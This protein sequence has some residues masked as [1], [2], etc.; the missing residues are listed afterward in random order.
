[1]VCALG[2]TG[3]MAGPI[4]PAMTFSIDAQSYSSLLNDS[5]YANPMLAADILTPPTPGKPGPNAPYPA[6]QTPTRPGTF[7]ANYPVLGSPPGLDLFAPDPPY[8][9]QLDA[10]SFGRDPLVSPSGGSTATTLQYAFSVDE[11]A[12]GQSNT[13]V[14]TEGALGAREAA[15][16][17]FLS[18]PVSGM[19][20]GAAP[21]TNT[22]Y[23]DGNGAGSGGAPGIGLVE[24][25]PPTVGTGYVIPPN[26]GPVQKDSGDNLDAVDFDTT[27][28][29]RS[30][31]L[32]FSL[33]SAFIDPL[34][35]KNGVVPPNFGSAAI[36]GYVGGDVLVGV[37]LPYGQGPGGYGGGHAVYAPAA[38]LGLDRGGTDT[39]DLDALSLWEN[40][41]AGYQRSVT[42][43]DWLTGGTDMLLFSVRRN[44]A[45]IGMIDSILG[46]AI[47]EGDILTTPC[48]VGSVL[49]NGVVCKGGATPGIFTAAEWLGLATVRSGNGKSWGMV[50]PIYGQ[51]LWADDL[52]ALDQVVVAAPAPAPTTSKK[53]KTTRK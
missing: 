43:F 45:V 14:R 6:G 47:E 38:A 4:V 26:Q 28:A 18:A 41:V 3:A 30:G 53:R 52:D 7:I 36:H 13:A 20:V 29:D 42:P 46:L 39:D 50:N 22:Q 51:D 16:D 44:S 5:F 49:P 19:P 35:A 48:P 24:P 11:F 34:E 2:A 8:V 9:V 31:P 23:T 21:G 27:L 17:T 1:M 25:N 33:D 15:A 12:I 40:G 32:Y 10:L 37:P